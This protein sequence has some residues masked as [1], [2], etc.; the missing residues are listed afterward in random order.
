MKY[1]GGW[2]LSNQ[3]GVGVI[4][5]EEDYMKVQHYED[6]PETVEIQYDEDGESYIKVGQLELY[7]N[8]CI[9]FN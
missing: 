2:V 5:V 3:G 6:E 8:E 7:L 9:R 4:E 1:I